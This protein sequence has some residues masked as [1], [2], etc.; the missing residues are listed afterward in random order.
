MVYGKNLAEIRKAELES[1]ITFC[2]DKDND[3]FFAN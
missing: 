2:E 3:S 1:L